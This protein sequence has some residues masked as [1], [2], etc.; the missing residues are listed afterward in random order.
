MSFSDGRAL[1]YLISHYLPTLLPASQ[2]SN[3]TTIKA[4]QKLFSDSPQA[5]KVDENGNWA[6]AFS[7]G[8]D[9]VGG[10]ERKS[11][12]ENEKKNFK[13]LAEKVCEIFLF[14]SLSKLIFS[15]RLEIFHHFR[16]IV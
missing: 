15:H 6:A 16:I 7:P 5:Q 11:R 9:A 14:L 12:L 10:K 4:S 8:V 1:C 13:L 2:I 3:D